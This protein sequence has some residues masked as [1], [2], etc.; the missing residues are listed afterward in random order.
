MTITGQLKGFA[1]S[2][3]DYANEF[4][5]I[6]I[7]LSRNLP[8]VEKQI[9]DNLTA[10]R[11]QMDLSFDNF[12][13]PENNPDVSVMAEEIAGSIKKIKALGMLMDSHIDMMLSVNIPDKSRNLIIKSAGIVK[14]F[15][16]IINELLNRVEAVKEPIYSIMVEMQKQ[17]II[18]QQIE[19]LI[20]AMDDILYLTETE[21][22]DKDNNYNS[23]LQFLLRTMEKQLVRINKDL[24]AMINVIEDQFSLIH[25]TLIRISH[26]EFFFSQELLQKEYSD[27]DSINQ[28]ILLAHIE[29]NCEKLM[30]SDRISFSESLN[31]I[32]NKE[33]VFSRNYASIMETTE[34]ISKEI[35]FYTDFFKKL[36][37]L[38]SQ[39]DE[40]IV[41]CSDLRKELE[42]D[43]VER[44]G[45]LKISECFFKDRV[46]QKIVKKCSVE[47]ERNTLLKEFPELDI[48]MSEKNRVTLF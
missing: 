44:G 31:I 3:N 46:I 4:Q 13:Y 32:K 41:F 22:I 29:K 26:D 10:I 7:S 28:L 33:A 19:H 30:F 6:I 42:R 8:V 40:K 24:I 34:S 21:N 20:E 9:D 14:N 47:D 16:V 1:G 12:E 27:K 11:Q 17:D 5:N 43:L 38:H 37:I 36:R 45:S 15:S 39:M 2:L 23:L 25:L 18:Q 35:S 48:E